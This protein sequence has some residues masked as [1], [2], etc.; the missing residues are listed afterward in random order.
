MS[1]LQWNTEQNV[2]TST[3]TLTLV[4]AGFHFEPTDSTYTE[5]WKCRTQHV[6]PLLL[7]LT[8]LPGDQQ[9]DPV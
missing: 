1:C 5:Q 9:C 7:L 4:S 8:Q 6:L 3:A 2:L